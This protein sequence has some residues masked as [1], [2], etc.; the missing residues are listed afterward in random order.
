MEQP[1][2]IGQEVVCIH[3]GTLK[4]GRTVNKGDQFIVINLLQCNCGSWKVDVGLK[5]PDDYIGSCSC[6]CGN[7][8]S[9]DY[10][11]WVSAASL[12]PIERAKKNM[13]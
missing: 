9:T 1:F 7:R 6:G 10:T 12:A 13:W 4:G 8:Y 2:Y 3:G 5:I 11:A